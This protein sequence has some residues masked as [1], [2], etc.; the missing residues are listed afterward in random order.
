MKALKNTFL[1]LSVLLWGFV[2][3]VSAGE[4]RN[5]TGKEFPI[6]AWYSVLPKDATRQ[7]YEELR[8]AG[9]N[10]STSDFKTLQETLDALKLC[11]GTG[12][13][14][15][16]SCPEMFE[17]ETI[18]LL[19]KKKDNVAYFL[20]DEPTPKDFP[21]LKKLY[22]K[23]RAID[24]SRPVYLDLFPTYVP[25]EALG[26]RDYREYMELSIQQVGTG[27][28]S[29]DHYPI[30]SQGMR[31][32]YFENL[33]IALE[34]GKK[35]GQPF[36]AFV[37]SNPHGDYPVPERSHMRLQAFCN[38]A[39]GA[40]ALQYFT[41]WYAI[42]RP[43]GGRSETFDLVADLNREIQNLSWVFLGAE[44]LEVGHT[45]DSIP[46]GTNPIS[47]LPKQIKSVSSN[48]EGLLVSH[49]RNGKKDFL[50][51]VNRSR[52]QRQL[53]TIELE[54]DVQRV[55]PS[56]KTC[57][58]KLYSKEMWMDSGDYLLYEW[59]NTNLKSHKKK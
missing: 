19:S 39:Y 29:F 43:D 45:G 12:V 31:P 4:Y 14:I 33:E 59:D 42:I 41:Y 58:A 18:R 1:I 36:W 35:Y 54:D 9:F 48:G 47:Y 23:I 57:S 50:M 40:Q 52:F 25:I 30:L 6:L 26:T 49:L 20:R 51:V 13:K 32:D 8:E 2:M 27:F 10:M 21:E 5:P 38:L 24:S 16:V 53:A 22:D 37:L 11:H 15:V 3:Q 7:R 55:L 28:I 44:V 34:L 46:Q 17:D 56:G